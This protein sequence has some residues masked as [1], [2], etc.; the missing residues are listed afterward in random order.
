MIPNGSAGAG[1]FIDQSLGIAFHSDS[2]YLRGIKQR[3]AVGTAANVNGAIMPAMSENDT[4]DNPHNPMYGIYS[5]GYAALTPPAGNKG[6]LLAL[7]GT[8]SSTSG[9]NSMAPSY[10]IDPDGAADQGVAGLGRDR[11]G[12]HRPAG[13]T[14]EP[15]RCHR[16]ARV[17]RAH[18]RQQARRGQ[19]AA[20][21][22]GCGGQGPGAVRLRRR[23]RPGGSLRQCQHHAEPRSG[24][25]H[26]R[27]R[28]HLHAPPNTRP[29]RTSR[30]PPRS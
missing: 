3:V 29:I 9:G 23:C 11:T 10:M 18:Q 26:R 2:A 7:I 15:E 13:R 1:N 17:D 16:G 28:R 20:R 21:R 12:E 5:S 22:A 6:D 24:Y 4:G 14:A 30:P 27:F 8:E 19:Y 25:Q